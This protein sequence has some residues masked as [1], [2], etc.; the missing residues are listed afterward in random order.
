M[1]PVLDLPPHRSVVSSL[2]IILNLFISGFSKVLEPARN[3]HGPLVRTLAERSYGFKLHGSFYQY[4]RL[5][6]RCQ[7]RGQVPDASPTCHNNRAAN[8]PHFE[9]ESS[10]IK[11]PLSVSIVISPLG[12][13]S[14]RSWNRPKSFSDI[15]IGFCKSRDDVLEKSLEAA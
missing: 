13:F 5:P 2:R 14:P 4:I 8:Q 7:K 12:N 1:R 3:G 6:V 9:I 10:K 15:A 11:C